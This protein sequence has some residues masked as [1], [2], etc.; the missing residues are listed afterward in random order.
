[1]YTRA[2]LIFTLPTPKNKLAISIITKK[3]KICMKCNK[4]LFHARIGNKNN[5]KIPNKITFLFVRWNLFSAK[6]K[7]KSIVCVITFQASNSM[8][9]KIYVCSKYNSLRRTQP[10][11][12]VNRSQKSGRARDTLRAL[13]AHM[14]PDNNESLWSVRRQLALSYI[15]IL[16]QKCVENAFHF[17][18]PSSDA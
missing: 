14:A 1:M 13:C 10:K 9:N 7:K 12:I 8:F 2:T 6:W 3:T 15:L 17:Y 18:S 16:A 5:W 11:L 4:K